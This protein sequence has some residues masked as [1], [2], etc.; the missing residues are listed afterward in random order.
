M[1]LHVLGGGSEVGAS[2][3]LVEAGASRLVVDCGIRMGAS[4]SALPDLAGL[5]SGPVD[6]IVLT[7]AHMDHCGALPLLHASMQRVPIFATP[8]TKELVRV[9]LGDALRVMD[10][11]M[12]REQELPLY[13]P[14]AV[15]SMLSAMKTVPLGCND[16]KQAITKKSPYVSS[17]RATSLV[18]P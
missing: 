6:A 11:R 2:M 8:A 17:L 9:M 13:P 12:A 10:D 15:Q 4:G 5:G 7:H 3:M 16:S 1:R 18:L 14:E